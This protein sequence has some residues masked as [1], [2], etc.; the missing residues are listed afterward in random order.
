MALGQLS[1]V[2]GRRVQQSYLPAWEAARAAVIPRQAQTREDQHRDAALALQEK[3]QAQDADQ[4]RQSL[5]LARRQTD[6]SEQ[7]QEQNQEQAK[8]AQR[9]GMGSLVVSTGLGL[10]QVGPDLWGGGEDA[11]KD[12]ASA[13]M[14]ALGTGGGTKAGADAVTD[15][16]AGAPG[17]GDLSMLPNK[18]FGMN[19]FGKNGGAAGTGNKILDGLKTHGSGVLSSMISPK[20]VT[21][22][23]TAAPIGGMIGEKVIP[24]GGPN[25]KA[26]LGAGLAS[27]G[28]GALFS[29]ATGMNKLYDSIGTGVVGTGIQAAL[30]FFR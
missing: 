23:L 10:K 2:T 6:L 9:Y 18:T 17:R 19:A 7:A 25:E 11:G 4:A 28:A 27:M 13:A 16:A 5:G 3:Q 30:N 1:R 29:S 20:N 21:T 14:K 22:A 26:L 15:V 12:G 24:F 8:R